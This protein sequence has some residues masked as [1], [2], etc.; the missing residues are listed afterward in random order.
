M[1]LLVCGFL[2]C[3]IFIIF[4]KKKRVKK[5]NLQHFYIL[6]PFHLKTTRIAEYNI[7]SRFFFLIPAKILYF[8]KRK[9]WQT[10]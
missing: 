3:F 8:R 1:F 10:F 2:F 5:E 7:F 4:K 6:C 9:P